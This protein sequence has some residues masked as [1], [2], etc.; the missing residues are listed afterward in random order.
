MKSVNIQHNAVNQQPAAGEQGKQGIG[1]KPP[2]MFRHSAAQ[3]QH[4]PVAQLVKAYRAES[5]LDSPK[6]ETDTSDTYIKLSDAAHAEGISISFENDEH[7]R[8]FQ[9]GCELVITMDFKDSIYGHI[10]K[11]FD[12]KKGTL[13]K[14]FKTLPDPSPCSDPVM[15]KELQGKISPQQVITFQKEWV[16]ELEKAISNTSVEIVG[17]DEIDDTTEVVAYNAEDAPEERVYTTMSKKD[18]EDSEFAWVS[19]N[20]AKK[21]GFA[22]D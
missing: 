16:P 21:S 12:N 7:V 2:P 6:I 17:D 1:L 4:L 18:A 19:I 8:Y 14:P 13:P 11:I 22:V 5:S 9:K 10:K 3:L 15:G 20:R